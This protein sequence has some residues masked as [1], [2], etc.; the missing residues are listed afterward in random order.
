LRVHEHRLEALGLIKKGVD[1]ITAFEDSLGQQ[2]KR[3]FAL[4]PAEK[5]A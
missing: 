3:H 5:N 4:Q 2:R 1:A